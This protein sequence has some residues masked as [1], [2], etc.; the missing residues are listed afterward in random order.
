MAYDL[1]PR[2]KGVKG[3]TVGAFSWPMFLQETGA[4]YVI[5]Y[6]EGMSPGSYVY[7]S[8]NSG[9]PVSNDNY[10]VTSAEAKAM[11]MCM[12]GYITVSAFI[13]KEWEEKYPNEAERKKMQAFICPGTNKLLYNT[14]MAQ[15]RLEELVK[16]ADFMEASGGFTIS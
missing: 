4:G 11:A 1:T 14:P 13:N 7:Q 5:G 16:I 10:R 9:S 2:K 6:G 15:V 12:R 3:I 8:N